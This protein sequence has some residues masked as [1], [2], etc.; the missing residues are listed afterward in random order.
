M[1]AGE[2]QYFTGIPCKNGHTCNRFTSSGGCTKCVAIHTSRYP[3]YPEN[4][5]KRAVSNAKWK[6]ANREQ[7]RISNAQYQQQH[8]HDSIKAKNE[9][10]KL[11][12][13]MIAKHSNAYRAR[14][15]SADG[16][17]TGEDIKRLWDRQGHKCAVPGCT[18]A[19]AGSGKNIY[20][21]DHIVPLAKGGSNYPDNLQCLCGVHN[22]SKNARDPYRWAQ[23]LELDQ[24][25]L[26][27]K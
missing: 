10:R 17:H 14:K 18:N 12:P 20:H 2:K 8:K 11:R 1:A 23:A 16:T 9:R 27:V 3:R 26:F 22:L 25:L 15:V 6:K 19:I 4:P 13:E 24:R 21:V 7:T 5:E